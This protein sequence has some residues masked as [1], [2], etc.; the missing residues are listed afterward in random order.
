MTTHVPT[1]QTVNRKWHLLDAQDQI[2]GRLATTAA[3]KIMGKNKSDFIRHVDMGDHV[4]ILNAEKV[5]TTGNKV[6]QKLY[7]RHS[8]YPGGFRE[9][10]LEKLKQE[11]P[12]EVVLNAVKGMLP[13]NK[14]KAKMLTRLHII[15]GS[16]NLYAQHFK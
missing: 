16:D 6:T 14:L 5:V 12:A 10:T 8:G 9:I 1:L 3:V 2:L 7:R 15:V 13:D 11:K 4:V